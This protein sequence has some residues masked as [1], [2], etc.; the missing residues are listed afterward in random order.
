MARMDISFLII[1]AVLC[2]LFKIRKLKK[3]K[4]ERIRKTLIYKYLKGE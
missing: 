1:Y 4:R 3:K 2:L